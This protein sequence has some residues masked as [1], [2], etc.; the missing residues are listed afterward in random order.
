RW[1]LDQCV[2]QNHERQAEV[3]LQVA[4]F[5][6]SQFGVQT[7]QN[8][9]PYFF[10]QR[11][12]PDPQDEEQVNPYSLESLKETETLTRLATGIQRINLPDDLNYIRLYQQVVELGKSNWGENALGQLVSIFEN[13]RQYPTAAK[14]LRQSI[15]EY[16]DPHQNK[17]QQLNQIVGNWGQFD[18]NPSQV[19][20]Q[21]AEVDYRFRNGQH[22]EFEAYQIHVE[23]LLT[24][25]KNY[26]K[27]H[28]EKLEWD[29]VNISNIGY[30]LVHEQQ[31]KYQ[32]P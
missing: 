14:Y 7:L 24:D 18:P 28:P 10:S 13:R 19:A 11:N 17:Q 21:G 3:I 32:G 26:L 12:E 9:M 15:A 2:K 16:G 20:G 6:R 25:V 23:K 30:R 8:F 27:T 22:V 29:Q 1:M 5:N 4:D 31:K